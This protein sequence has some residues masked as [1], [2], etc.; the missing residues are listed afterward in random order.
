MKTEEKKAIIMFFALMIPL[1]GS[2]LITLLILRGCES[3]KL[4]PVH[5]K[6]NYTPTNF[7]KL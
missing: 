1:S 5:F 6:E 7:N 3:N 2:L 4:K